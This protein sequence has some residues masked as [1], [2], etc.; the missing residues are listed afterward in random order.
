[1]KHLDYRMWK[2]STVFLMLYELMLYK[3]YIKENT[4]TQFIKHCLKFTYEKLKLSLHHKIDVFAWQP[5]FPDSLQLTEILHSLL[6][7]CLPDF[8]LFT[9]N[10]NAWCWWCISDPISTVSWDSAD[11]YTWSDICTLVCINACRWCHDGCTWQ[12]TW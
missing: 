9:A 6:P 10:P 4:C 3:L 2:N 12:S 5:Y 11:I 8:L 1:M 7:A